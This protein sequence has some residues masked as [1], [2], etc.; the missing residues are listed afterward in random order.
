[1]CI[2]ALLEWP[3]KLAIF[4]PSCSVRPRNVPKAILRSTKSPA[5]SNRAA[6]RKLPLEDLGFSLRRL[7]GVS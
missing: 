1:M 2:R 7:R 5:A 4:N 6:S 3:W